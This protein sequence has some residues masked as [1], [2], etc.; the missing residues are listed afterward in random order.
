MLRFLTKNIATNKP[1]HLRFRYLRN[2]YGKIIAVK[3]QV[4]VKHTTVPSIST[5]HNIN[6]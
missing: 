5:L 3:L 6:Y 4:T 2:S 1:K